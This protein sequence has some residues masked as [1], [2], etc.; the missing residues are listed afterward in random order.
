MF[1]KA[2]Y[3]QSS[4]LFSLPLSG[5]PKSQYLAAN[6]Q[7]RCNEFQICQSRPVHK[8]YEKMTNLHSQDVSQDYLFS[9]KPAG[10]DRLCS[11]DSSSRC[12]GVEF[13]DERVWEKDIQNNSVSYGK[14]L[15]HN[16]IFFLATLKC[17]KESSSSWW[18]KIKHFSPPEHWKPACLPSPLEHNFYC[19]AVMKCIPSSDMF[20]RYCP[21]WDKHTDKQQWVY[22]NVSQYWRGHG[23]SISRVIS[24]AVS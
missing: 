2:L 4:L 6:S 20:G 8:C 3:K 23:R 11:L 9:P 13:P 15:H 12:C 16:S 7:K 10:R 19:N 17:K 24:Q 5:I 1:W 18:I 14:V 21:W 22:L